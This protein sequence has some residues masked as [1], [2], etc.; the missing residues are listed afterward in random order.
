M[1]KAICLLIFLFFEFIIGNW[2]YA[3]YPIR[4]GFTI[5][6]NKYTLLWE[7]HWDYISFQA[8]A[9]GSGYVGFGI[10]PTGKG[11]DGSDL[12]I[13]GVFANGTVYGHVR[14]V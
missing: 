14:N 2:A 9:K 13:S 3:Q 12:F 1:V 4:G 11:M 6:D 5:N 10:S 8:M 7:V